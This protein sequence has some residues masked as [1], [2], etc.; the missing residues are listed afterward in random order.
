MPRQEDKKKKKKANEKGKIIQ[1]KKKKKKKECRLEIKTGYEIL[2]ILLL[3]MST[4]MSLLFET[5]CTKT[6]RTLSTMI[7][8]E[9]TTWRTIVHT[10]E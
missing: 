6:A 1:M 3:I 5:N 8:N 9:I 2:L 10:F 7:E 4:S